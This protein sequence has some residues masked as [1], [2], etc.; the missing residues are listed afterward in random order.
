MLRFY[1]AIYLSLLCRLILSVRLSNSLRR[2]DVLLLLEF[3]NI[4]PIL[5]YNFIE[6]ITLLNTFLVISFSQGKEYMIWRNSLSMFSDLLPAF[7][8]VS[9]TG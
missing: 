5:F 1:K 7:T 2:R 6:F 3:I 9:A 4:V 8:F